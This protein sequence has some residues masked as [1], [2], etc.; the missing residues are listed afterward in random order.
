MSYHK[1]VKDANYSKITEIQTSNKRTCLLF[2]N[3]KKH[4]LYV[5]I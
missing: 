4:P 3:F 1:Q 5:V 2:K